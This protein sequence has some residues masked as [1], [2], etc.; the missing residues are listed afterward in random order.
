MEDCCR[1]HPSFKDY[2]IFNV[3]TEMSQPPGAAPSAPLSPSDETTTLANV[4]TAT[5]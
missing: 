2:E 3:P 4:L 5:S 1:E